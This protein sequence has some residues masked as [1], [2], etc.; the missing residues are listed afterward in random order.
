LTIPHRTAFE[1]ENGMVP[2][3]PTYKKFLTVTNGN[4]STPST[5]GMRQI[6][7]ERCSPGFACSTLLHAGGDGGIVRAWIPSLSRCVRR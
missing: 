3:S 4:T 1:K 2:F 5:N 6:A 7:Q